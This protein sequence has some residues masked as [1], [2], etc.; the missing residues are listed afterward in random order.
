MNCSPSWCATHI[1]V[2]S[3]QQL[4][5]LISS[6]NDA[7]AHRTVNVAMRRLRKQIERNDAWPTLVVSVRR[8]GYRF[9]SD[10]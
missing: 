6:R 1:G 5:D 8:V 2:F 9:N 4:V 10:G 7:V 3:R